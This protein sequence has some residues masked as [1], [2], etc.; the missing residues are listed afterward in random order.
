MIPLWC[1]A[2]WSAQAPGNTSQPWTNW[3]GW[4]D[5]YLEASGVAAAPPAGEQQQR[6]LIWSL[7]AATQFLLFPKIYKR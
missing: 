5:T 7:A 3:G 6:T 2:E 1:T 4:S